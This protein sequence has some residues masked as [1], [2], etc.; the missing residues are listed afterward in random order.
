M[1]FHP[2]RLKLINTPINFPMMSLGNLHFTIYIYYIFQ[3]IKIDRSQKYWTAAYPELSLVAP[4]WITLSIIFGCSNFDP[5]LPLVECENRSS[6][7]VV[8]TP[9]VLFYND[10]AL[11]QAVNSFCQIKKREIF[12]LSTHL[13]RSDWAITVTKAHWKACRKIKVSDHLLRIHVILSC[14][15]DVYR[16]I[17][18]SRVWI[19]LRIMTIW[20]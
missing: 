16:V 13:I 8:I 10:K 6:Q 7:L 18:L 4:L 15:M 12:K 5:L 11:W 19:K 20:V 14:K 3:W 2:A 17:Q 9:Y 1:A